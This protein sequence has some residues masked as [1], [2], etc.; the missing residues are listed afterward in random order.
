[1]DLW[2]ENWRGHERT[3]LSV[4][5][6]LF[7]NSKRNKSSFL[8]NILF[9]FLTWNHPEPTGPDRETLASTLCHWP[10]PTSLT[11][12]QI[13]NPFLKPLD[14]NVSKVNNG[15]LG[16][17]KSYFG[18]GWGVESPKNEGIKLMMYRERMILT[19][20]IKF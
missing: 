8:I 7:W 15:W 16:G 13:E 18:T 2:Y 20:V 17:L 12:W 19:S 11:C 5:C 9:N 1:M 4:K 14:H 6:V 3:N 10:P